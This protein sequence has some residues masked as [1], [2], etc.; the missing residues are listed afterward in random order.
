MRAGLAWAHELLAYAQSKGAKGKV[1]IPTSGDPNRVRWVYEYESQ[2]QH[3]QAMKQLMADQ[4]YM[5]FLGKGADLLRPG[6]VSD[7]IWT[8]A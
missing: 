1:E 3:A 6:T 7:D 4:K 8:S 2:D 5:E